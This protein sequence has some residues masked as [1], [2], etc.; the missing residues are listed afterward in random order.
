MKHFETV[1]PFVNC[2]D[3]GEEDDDA[4]LDQPGPMNV[5]AASRRLLREGVK[6]YDTSFMPR[7]LEYPSMDIKS[8]L[9]N[10]GNEVK[11]L[12]LNSGKMLR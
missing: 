8:I 9:L 3:D 5:G 12:L 1:K 2:N 11:N 10:D 4:E 6:H 7:G